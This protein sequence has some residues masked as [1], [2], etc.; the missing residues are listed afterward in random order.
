[1]HL[2]GHWL[3]LGALGALGS[4]VVHQLAYLAVYPSEAHR[5]A[6]LV[7][8]GHLSTQ[9]ALVAPAAVVAA[10]VFILRQARDLGLG[11]DLSAVRL[12]S[13]VAMAFGVQELAETVIAGAAP[14]SV[15]ANPAVLVGLVLT[16]VVGLAFARMLGAVSEVVRRFR[17]AESRVV[18]REP[19]AR[20]SRPR[21]DR[22]PS[23][24]WFVAGPTRGPPPVRC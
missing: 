23:V 16:P 15:L 2:R 5:A 22:A 6:E 17:L 21:S 3:T 18:R 19:A 24:H 7:D 11:R 20:T 12:A 1:M 13:A 10:A 9:W 14:W 4:L 8:H